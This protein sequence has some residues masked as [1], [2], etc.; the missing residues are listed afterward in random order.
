[1]ATAE[2]VEAE[3]LGP[4]A[5]RGSGTHGGLAAGHRPG[6]LDQGRPPCC[7]GVRPD[8]SDGRR[9]HRRGSIRFTVM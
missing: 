8:R 4:A 7:A 3:L 5:V 1:V 2:Q 9:R 6:H